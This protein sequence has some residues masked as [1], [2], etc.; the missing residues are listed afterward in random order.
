MI[1]QKHD[2]ACIFNYLL[3]SF[4]LNK[5]IVQTP[6]N[7]FRHSRYLS[8]LVISVLAWR[9]S[10]VREYRQLQQRRAAA[11][12]RTLLGNNATE[13]VLEDNYPWLASLP[14]AR[15]HRHRLNWKQSLIPECYDATIH[16]AKHRLNV[17]APAP[18]FGEEESSPKS[19]VTRRS[20]IAGIPALTTGATAGTTACLFHS[21]RACHQVHNTV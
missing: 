20:S 17:F 13:I 11:R 12:R 5:L 6:L 14:Q 19:R 21:V 10:V 18:C 4:K 3:R 15:I 7:K 1:S 16:W 9:A 2:H 8:F